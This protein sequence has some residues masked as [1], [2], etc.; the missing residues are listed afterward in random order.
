MK[1]RVIEQLVTTSSAPRGITAEL[2][3]V[4]DPKLRHMAFFDSFREKPR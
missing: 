4:V 2:P 1:Y 3:Q